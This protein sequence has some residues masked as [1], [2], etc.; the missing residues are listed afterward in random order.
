MKI[1]KARKEDI[2]KCVDIQIET[3]ELPRKTLKNDLTDQLNDKNFN[4]L[5]I[6]ENKQIIGFITTKTVR[7]N[8][9]IYLENI[10]VRKDHWNK[11]IGSKLLE[12]TKQIANNEKATRIF[13]DTGTDQV[14]FYAKSGF[15][16]AGFIKDWDR[17]DPKDNDAVIMSYNV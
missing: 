7:W 1:R 8:Q 4:F 2:D 17:G 3:V 6:E 9:S 13:L 11:G 10:F 15:K 5:I 16:V 12:L 14:K